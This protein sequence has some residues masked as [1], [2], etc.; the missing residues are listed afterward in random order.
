MTVECGMRFL[1]DYLMGDKYFSIEYPTQNL[2]RCRA[3]FKL[4]REMEQHF[5]EMEQVLEE[6]QTQL[7]T[8]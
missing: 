3:Q 2:D 5:D 8:Q 6:V 4:A 1:T 7:C